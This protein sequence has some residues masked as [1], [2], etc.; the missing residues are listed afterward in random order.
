[1]RYVTDD[2]TVDFVPLQ[3][4]V[5]CISDY[6]ELQRLRL[7]DNTPVQFAVRGDIGLK[8]IPP[9]I[10]MTFIENTFKY[11]ISKHNSS[12]IDITSRCGL[13]RSIGTGS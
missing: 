3:R 11:G 9:L 2:L 1:M 5:D 6:I 8:V 4:E 10:L 7:N 12:P 13:S